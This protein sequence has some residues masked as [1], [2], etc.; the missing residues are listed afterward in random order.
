MEKIKLKAYAKINIG[1]DVIGKRPDGYHEVNMVMQTV[2]LH[3]TVYLSIRT[4]PEITVRTN[5]YYLPCN[6]NNLAY[7]AAKL[8]MEEF[9]LT[10]GID[11]RLKKEIPVAAGMAGGSTDAATVLVGMNRLFELGLT[12]KELMK[13]GVQLGAD[14]PYCI[15]RGTALAEGIGE[16]LTKLPPMPKCVVLVAKPPVSVSTKNVYEL[17]DGMHKQEH[18]D[19][20][21]ILE[22]IKCGKLEQIIPHMGNIL[23]SVTVAMHPQIMYLKELMLR[24]GAM[25][26]MMSG[27]GPAVF[28]FFYQKEQAEKVANLLKEKNLVQQVNVTGIFNVT[29]RK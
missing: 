29:E 20:P 13:R 28:G 3:D 4:K 5:L 1:L 2:T 6:E 7:Q 17:L 26:A 9:H 23:E 19:I 16:Q 22:G 24:E 21:G 18:P 10:N 8:L 27:S 12:R 25:Q 15:M 11:I 14:V